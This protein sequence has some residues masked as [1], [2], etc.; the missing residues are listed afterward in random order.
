MKPTETLSNK[1]QQ[2]IL[3]TDLERDL[4]MAIAECE[5][6]RI[7]VI[8][9]RNTHAH[10]MGRLSTFRCLH[11]VITITIEPSDAHK[12]LTTLTAVWQQLQEHGATRHSLVICLGGGVVTDLG[13][14]AAATFKRGIN[15][16]NIP[17]SLLGMVDASVGGKTGVNFGGLKNEIGCFQEASDVII[18][19]RFLATLPITELKSG[20][21]EMLKHVMLSSHD[22]FIKL[23]N[24]DFQNADAEHLLQLLKTSVLVKEQIVKEDPHEQGIRRALNLGHTVGHAFESKALH[25]GKPIAHGYAVAWGMVAEMVLSHHIL[26]F[27]TEDLHRLADFV[28]ANYGAYHIT[29]DHY[30]ELLHLMHHDKKS[31]HGEINCTLL[32]ACGDVRPGHTITDDQ[33]RIALDLYRDLLHI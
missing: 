26:K 5:H 15:F 9:D 8:A 25:D 24:Y 27:P 32:A 28:Y 3:T 19:T 33:M 16:I 31:E 2:V 21:A 7:F 18:S 11:D 12:D 30:D 22:E 6:D 10:C 13:G 20:Y 14:M 17:T 1:H 23:I 29:C 4:T